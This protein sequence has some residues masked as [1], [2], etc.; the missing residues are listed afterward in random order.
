MGKYR[1]YIGSYTRGESKGIYMYD[2]S[3]EDQTFKEQGAVE[4][5]NPSFLT[6]SADGRYLYSNCDEGVAAFRILP[7]GDLEYLNRHSV[8]GLRPCYLQV[9]SKNEYLVSSGYYD[10]KLTVSRINPDGTVGEVTDEV[11]MKTLGS[12]I[13]R[14]NR[15]HVNCAR[16]TPDE[17]YILAV[18]LGS[19]QI[20]VYGFDRENGKLDLKDI[21]RCEIDSGPKHIIF[22]NDK[23][24]IYLTHEN[25]NMVTEYKYSLDEKGPVFEKIDQKSTLPPKFSE[26]NCA[27]TLKISDDD[28]YLFVTNSGDNSVAIYKIDEAKKMHNLCVLPVSGIYPRDMY[29]FPDQKHFA[30]VN[31]ESDSVTFFNVDYEKGCIFRKG[32]PL[33]VPCP[34]CIAVKE[35][36]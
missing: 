23:Q 24:Y 13:S 12:V 11:F 4:I 21:I 36:K 29:L 16:F 20:K 2:F 31:Q 26:D 32:K 33:K 18:D 15:C 35:I 28:Q 22:S 6:L 8:Q 34:T 19:D 7:N 30:S 5:T 17:K 1:A 27:V 10:G 25:A 14:N 9:D 3:S